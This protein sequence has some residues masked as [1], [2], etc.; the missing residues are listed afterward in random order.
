MKVN[1]ILIGY[2]RNVGQF[3]DKGTGELVD[4]SNRIV[5]FITNSGASSSQKGKENI[6]YSQFSEKMKLAEL[7]SILGVP[8]SNEAVDNALND[9]LQKEV[10]TSFAPVNNV[11]T[12]VYFAPLPKS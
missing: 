6:G 10:I 5:R 1:T 8:E 11:M 2:Q 3:T 9:L 7:A 12:L 4:Y